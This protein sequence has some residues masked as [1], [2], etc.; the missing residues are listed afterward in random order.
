MNTF[1]SPGQTGIL[2]FCRLRDSCLSAYWGPH[3]PLGTILLWCLRYFRGPWLALL[4]LRGANLSEGCTPDRVEIPHNRSKHS[5]HAEKWIPV[6][7]QVEQNISVEK[8][9]SVE[10]NNLQRLL[11]IFIKIK[12]ICQ[13]KRDSF[14]LLVC[15]N[16]FRFLVRLRVAYFH[17]ESNDIFEKCLRQL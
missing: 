1:F 6:S 7:C 3:K 2:F 13:M 11:N 15:N 10:R 16:L 8:K 5:V 14:A 17:I 12:W 4:T 9:H